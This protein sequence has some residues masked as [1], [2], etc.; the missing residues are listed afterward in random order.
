MT[1]AS[2]SCVCNLATGHHLALP[3]EPEPFPNVGY[4]PEQYVLLVGDGYDGE[5]GAGAGAGAAV[6]R[7]FQVLKAKLVLSNSNRRLMVQTFSS[8]HG[9]TREVH[10]LG[11]AAKGPGRRRRRALA[12]PDR[13]RELRAHAPRDSGAGERDGSPGELPPSRGPREV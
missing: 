8:L 9:A 3:P 4:N 1:G 7:P 11:I 10:L 13:R 5:V 12:V 2:F 6:G